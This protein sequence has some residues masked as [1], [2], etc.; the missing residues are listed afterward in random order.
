LVSRVGCLCSAGGVNG[1]HLT[2]LFV[3]VEPRNTGGVGPGEFCN[4]LGKSRKNSVLG[5]V[6]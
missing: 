3:H 6:P 5:G 4:C 2:C 1:Y